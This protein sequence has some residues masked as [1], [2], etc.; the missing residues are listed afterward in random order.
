MER[1]TPEAIRVDRDGEVW[2]VSPTG[3]FD[4]DNVQELR[5]ALESLIAPEHVALSQ[6]TL[7]VLDLSAITL[8]DSTVINEIIRAHRLAND[9]PDV[10]LAIV[11]DSPES[12]TGRIFRLVGIT[13]LLP[14]YASRTLALSAI[15]TAAGG[16]R[17]AAPAPKPSA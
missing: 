5:V 15:R 17:A 7:V 8:M 6:P 11:V 3:E 16:D 2:L 12:F 10:H 1:S 4:V 14:T 9:R 13:R